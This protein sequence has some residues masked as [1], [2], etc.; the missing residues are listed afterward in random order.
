MT[1]FWPLN[2]IYVNYFRTGLVIL[3]LCCLWNR[4]H[5]LSDKSFNQ[6]TY[7]FSR[8]EQPRAALPET[9]YLL[10]RLYNTADIVCK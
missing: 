7:S 2:P 5:A 10:L 9:T 8:F 4:L 3:L 6:F 1:F